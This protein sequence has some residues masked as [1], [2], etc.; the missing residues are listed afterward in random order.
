MFSVP[1]G[2]AVCV[3]G[4]SGGGK[5]TLCDA[6]TGALTDGAAALVPKGMRIAQ[7]VATGS[8]LPWL[9]VGENVRV[10]CFLRHEKPS[11]RLEGYLRKLGLPISTVGARL[12][13]QLSLGMRQR[14][15]LAIALSISLDLLVIDEGLSGLDLER[16]EA[17]FQLLRAE[18]LATGGSLIL[19]T[20]SLGDVVS[21]GDLLYV[22][23]EGQL[24]PP[25]SLER[26][27]GTGGK[28]ADRHLEALILKGDFISLAKH[29]ASHVCGAGASEAR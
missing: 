10:E 14:V 24:S 8:M 29:A 3:I 4:P 11:G 7:L 15:E 20:H 1:A 2:K 26:K 9:T 21:F 25:M 17:A 13:S 22:I 27:P 23:V 18:L 28:I 16:R 6:V 12:P 5:S 19:A